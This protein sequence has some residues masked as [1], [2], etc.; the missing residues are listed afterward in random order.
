MLPSGAGRGGEV[1]VQPAAAGADRERLDRQ[2][3]PV[4]FAQ[5]GE[6]VRAVGDAGPAQ[7][8]GGVSPGLGVSRSTTT[9]PDG[10]VAMPML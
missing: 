2:R 6:H 8:G 7:S 10:P 4:P 3:L 1:Q 9:R 5:R